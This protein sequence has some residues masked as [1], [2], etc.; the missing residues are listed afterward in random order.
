MVRRA[1]WRRWGPSTASTTLHTS[2]SGGGKSGASITVPPST[3]VTDTATLT[4]TN[5]ASATGTVT[6]DAYSDSACTTAVGQWHG[7]DH[8]HAGH[9]A[10]VE[11]GHAQRRDLLLAGVVLR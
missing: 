8:H 9:A 11:R 4:G 6:Y 3:A 10:P 7:Q 1:K 5:A 2:L